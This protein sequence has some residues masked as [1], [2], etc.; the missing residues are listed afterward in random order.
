MLARL[1]DVATCFRVL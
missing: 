1:I